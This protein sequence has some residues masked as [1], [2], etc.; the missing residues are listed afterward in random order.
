VFQIER[1]VANAQ[2]GV[3]A[4]ND[5]AGAVAHSPN[6]KLESAAMSLKFTIKIRKI[7]FASK[8]TLLNGLLLVAF[9]DAL[10]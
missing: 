9:L 2:R 6:L 8:Y 5:D 3:G 4:E 10:A 7:I 1:P